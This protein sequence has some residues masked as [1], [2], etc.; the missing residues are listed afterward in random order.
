VPEHPVLGWFDRRGHGAERQAHGGGVGRGQG[1]VG[2]RVGAERLRQA[3]GPTRQEEPCGVGEEGGGRRAVA[4]A[5]MLHRLAVVCPMSPGTIKRCIH[6]LERR[7]LSA[8]I[9][10][11]LP[12]F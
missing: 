12:H 9:P 8:H 10:H 7:R 1:G 11:P 2:E 6:V 3:I 5:G 4:G